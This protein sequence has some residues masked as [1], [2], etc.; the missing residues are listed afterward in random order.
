VF[1]SWI[2]CSQCL[3]PVATPCDLLVCR[4]K[5]MPVQQA[6]A[7]YSRQSTPVHCNTGSRDRLPQAPAYGVQCVLLPNISA[8]MVT[9]T[10]NV[11][12]LLMCLTPQVRAEAEVIEVAVPMCNPKPQQP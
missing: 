1:R 4:R 7:C 5:R 2:P 6:H 10:T 12:N 3:D 9:C 8:A 11:Q